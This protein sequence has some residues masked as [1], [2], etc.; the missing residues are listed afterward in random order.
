MSP[1]P[2][3]FLIFLSIAAFAAAGPC[4]CKKNKCLP[5]P[6]TCYAPAPQCYCPPPPPPCYEPAQCFPQPL[7]YQQPPI[8]LPQPAPIG[9][10]CSDSTLPIS[11]GINI[12]F[13]A[14]A[15]L[16]KQCGVLC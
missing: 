13:S 10:P 4:C 9:I 2:K 14:L 12:G 3:I 11:G 16:L 5:P 15:P 7:I 1:L 8:Y 6:P